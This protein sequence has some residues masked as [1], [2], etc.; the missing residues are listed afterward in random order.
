MRILPVIAAIVAVSIAETSTIARSA[1]AAPTSI[2]YFN[3]DNISEELRSLNATEIRSEQTASGILLLR[4]KI[5]G[6]EFF[7]AFLACSTTQPGCLGLLLGVGFRMEEG[8]K[9]SY[10]LVNEYNARQPFSKAVR[11][12]TGEVVALT[13]YAISDGG[14]SPANLRS[15]ISN[16]AQTVDVFRRFEVGRRQIASL[17]DTS[18]TTLR[19]L[20]EVSLD[21]VSVQNIVQTQTPISHFHHLLR[22][23]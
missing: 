11:V 3:V 23:R 22:E 8:V 13:R 7:A 1:S 4:Y 20:R 18:R 5:D 15:N 9:V 12:D 14:I 6:T 17:V 19:P 10:E 2:E 21:T 16:F